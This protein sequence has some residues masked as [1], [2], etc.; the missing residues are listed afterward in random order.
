MNEMNSIKDEFE[1]AYKEYARGILRHAYFRVSNQ[2]IAEDLVQE[3]FFKA[4]RYI[5]DGKSG[6]IKNFKA[7]LYK[8]LNNT[9][10]D[11]YRGKRDTC[12]LEDAIEKREDIAI[13]ED[14]KEQ[15]MD[16]E[17]EQKEL[18]K[19]LSELK[20]EY[21]EILI[22]RYIDDLSINEISKVLNK[23]SGN[24]RII[25]YRALKALKNKYEK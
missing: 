13:V 22:M 16:I 6:E 4:W 25:I 8:I 20:D 14:D 3:T 19:Y 2:E 7:F 23:S 12:S 11:Y 10:I 18:R 17:L 24:I 1:K 15:K 5:A 9:I 21:R